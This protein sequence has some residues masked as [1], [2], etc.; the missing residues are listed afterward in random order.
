L[1]SLPRSVARATG[2]ILMQIKRA[3]S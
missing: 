3:R 1:L 2:S